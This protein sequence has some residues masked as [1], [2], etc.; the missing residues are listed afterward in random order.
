MCALVYYKKTP[1]EVKI[2]SPKATADR[3]QEIKREKGK[4]TVQ[5][6]LEAKHKNTA[7]NS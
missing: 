3:K 1:K 7:E 4:K 6:K 2:T 5:T